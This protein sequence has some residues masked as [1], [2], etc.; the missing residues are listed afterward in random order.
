MSRPEERERQGEASSV[1]PSTPRSSIWQG[2]LGTAS[3]VAYALLFE[4]ARNL[5][6]NSLGESAAVKVAAGALRW[7][8][9][10][11]VAAAAVY[12]GHRFVQRYRERIRTANEL[13]MIADLADSGP[14]V[15]AASVR[16]PGRFVDA[17]W[18][19]LEIAVL[20]H[21]PV[22][23][24]E[25]AALLAVLAA[26]LDAPARLPVA[27]AESR[28]TAVTKLAELTR[29]GI[30]TPLGVQRHCLCKVPGLP[31]KW[32][33]TARPQWRA[34][35]TALV[36]FYADRATRWAFAL[37]SE[38]F[39]A[40]ARLWFDAEERG[41]RELVF[42]C[43]SLGAAVPATLVPELVRI[44]DALDGWYARIGKRENHRQLAAELNRIRGLEGLVVHRDLVQMRAGLLHGR[45]K[46][47]R[48]RN[49]STSLAARW[50]HRE[51]LRI[52]AES[53]DNLPAVAARLEAAWWLL[54]RED[55]AGEVCALINLAVVHIHQ[56]RLDAAQDRLE[57]AE[58]LTNA[59]REPDGRAQIQE[60]MGVVR[61]A[62]GDFRRALR[63][64]QRALTGYRTLADDPGTARCL[65]HLGSAMI[66]APEYS[67]TLF[68]A[69]RP[70]PSLE[71]QRQAS[72]WL[73]EAHRLHPAARH[74]E[75]Y[76]AK[77]R[78]VLTG[79]ELS[80]LDHI[81]HWPLA[82]MGR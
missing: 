77:A 35:L 46:R 1:E 74:T 76:I 53:P 12:V 4:L 69:D 15:R 73:A 28:A 10:L 16:H 81:D 24:F 57:L 63:C 61:W 59:G 22:R 42:A 13:E 7:L 29:A 26:V 32:E 2:F 58:S 56:G 21:L 19:D 41:L 44:G 34:A 40:G 38:Q 30:V 80:V 48:P 70:L 49:L 17:A 50:E 51:A 5:V 82:D 68:P 18:E 37:D 75:R 20:R 47:Y 72:G 36:H 27:Q 79:T 64:W 60:T 33:V 23:D 25:T 8:S 3:V 65:Q 67:D 39:A 11:V 6:L 52:L 55:V 43:A 14:P 78:W 45:P 31:A 66:V 62:R 54:P 71:V 9:V